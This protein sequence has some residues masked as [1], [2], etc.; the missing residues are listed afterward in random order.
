M[1]PPPCDQ[2][3]QHSTIISSTYQPF[4]A[5]RPGEIPV[6]QLYLWPLVRNKNNRPAG[7]VSQPQVSQLAQPLIKEWRHW[8]PPFKTG[9]PQKTHPNRNKSTSFPRFAAGL[10]PFHQKF[11]QTR[12]LL[13]QNRNSLPPTEVNNHQ[14]GTRRRHFSS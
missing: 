14:N 9:L 8:V 5:I 2:L 12:I 10:F 3:Y 6:C 4:R 11:P 13:S 7:Q 1:A